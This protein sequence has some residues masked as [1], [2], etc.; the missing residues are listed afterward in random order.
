MWGLTALSR[1][2]AGGQQVAR[3]ASWADRAADGVLLDRCRCGKTWTRARRAAHSQ[4]LQ[5]LARPLV[6]AAAI[7]SWLRVALHKNSLQVC[8]GF[9]CL[10]DADI[11]RP[12]F[13]AST[14]PLITM[15]VVVCVAEISTGPVYYCSTRLHTVFVA[16]RAS[17]TSGG[18]AG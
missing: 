12:G 5:L 17:V 1:A 9:R 3:V 4:Q 11:V 18:T 10:E 6:Q 16:G 13:M 2:W 15:A 14:V 8:K 7:S